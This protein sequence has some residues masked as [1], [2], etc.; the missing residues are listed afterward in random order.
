MEIKAYLYFF[1]AVPVGKMLIFNLF[2]FLGGSLKKQMK[3]SKT[4]KMPCC[5][6]I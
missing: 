1:I 5:R 2:T 6:V 3:V 4:I